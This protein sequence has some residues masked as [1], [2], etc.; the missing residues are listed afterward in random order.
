MLAVTSQNM[1][2]EWLTF[3]RIQEGVEQLKISA[4]KLFNQVYHGFPQSLRAN[5]VPRLFRFAVHY[6]LTLISVKTDGQRRYMT[7][8]D[9]QTQTHKP[10]DYG[11]LLSAGTPKPEQLQQQPGFDSFLSLPLYRVI[12]T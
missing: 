5:E 11:R 12:T 4:F 6:H 9:R 3:L 7:Y 10:N 1:A 8:T 2:V